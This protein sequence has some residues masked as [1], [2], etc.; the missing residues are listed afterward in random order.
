MRVGGKFGIDFADL[1]GDVE[2]SK[3]KTGFSAGVFFGVDLGTMFRLGIDG[4]YVQKG[5]KGDDVD[6][7]ELKINLDYLEFMVPFSVVVPTEGSVTPR[8]F[9]GPAIAFESSCKLEATVDGIDRSI[10]CDDEDIGLATK[11]IDL[12]LFFG[13]GV[14][15]AL[16]TGAF[17][18]D[19]LYNLGLSDI[20][21]V[22]GLDE[23]L[24]NKNIQFTIGYAYLFGGS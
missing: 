11:S 20:N 6:I 1:G 9:A 15:V 17:S 23:S 12:G 5:A 2:D 8:F 24:K 10:D 19:L 7:D 21:D 4:Q 16:G 13:L 18:F 14:D 22:E 3:I